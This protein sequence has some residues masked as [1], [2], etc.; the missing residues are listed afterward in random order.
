[1]KKRVKPS[2]SPA[3]QYRVKSISGAKNT[4]TQKNGAA[5]RAEF[6]L[7]I[8]PPD[9]HVPPPRP[10]GRPRYRSRKSIPRNEI[11]MKTI[12]LSLLLLNTL[13]CCPAFCGEI[14]DAARDGDL[15]KVKAL[16]KDNPDLVFSKDNVGWMPLEFAAWKGYKD[17]VELLLASNADVNAKDNLGD[18][19]LHFAVA[20][21]HKDVVELLLASKADVNAKD[22]AGETPLHEAAM[23]DHKDVAK[24]LLQHGARNLGIEV[25]DAVEAG[26]LQ[27]VKA[28]I[29]DNPDL[30]F[31]KNEGGLTPLHAA[32]DYGR[33]DVAE[34]LLVNKANINIKDTEGLTPLHRAAAFGHENIVELLLVNKAD[35]NS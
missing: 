30:V 34:F 32:A 17:I 2:S 27:K 29:K 35:I 33:K 5:A 19:P 10:R 23:K 13:L 26:D 31:C 28:L 8:F 15:E 20:N 3:E 16:L 6:K 14:H 22:K 25:Y 21:D 1:M 18:T 24:F 9:H 11:F 7:G 12:I 4:T